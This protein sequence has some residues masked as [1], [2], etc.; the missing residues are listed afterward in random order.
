MVADPFSGAR[1]SSNSPF[2]H[3]PLE[4]IRQQASQPMEVAAKNISM[5]LKPKNVM[6][7]LVA[8][9]IEAQLPHLSP[10]VKKQVKVPQIMAHA[11]NRLPSWYVTSEEGWCR[12][13][14]LRYD[15]AFNTD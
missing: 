4:K 7:V 15:D 6:E 9:E 11:L 13:W 5:E 14:R 12:Q 3:P 8:N 2:A 1:K 10:R